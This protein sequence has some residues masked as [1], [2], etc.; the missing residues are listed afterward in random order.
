MLEESSDAP[1][2][3]IPF[4]FCLIFSLFCFVILNLCNET[5]LDLLRHSEEYLMNSTK[6]KTELAQLVLSER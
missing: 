3:P 5:V 4:P 2:G 1:Y 6:S